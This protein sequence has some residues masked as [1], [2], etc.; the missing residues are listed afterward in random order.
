MTNW[1]YG[2]AG[3]RWPVKVGDI[4]QAGP[5]MLA[6]G[7]IE[8]G[9]AVELVMK[10]R[11]CPVMTYVDPPYTPALATGFR[12]KAG[13]PRKVDFQA[14]MR[15]I[16]R[17]VGITKGPVLM[18]MGRQYADE[19]TALVEQ[20]G[21]IVVSRWDITYFKKNPAVLLQLGFGHREPM[22]D[23]FSGMDDE[24]T[25]TVAIAAGSTPDALVF[26]PCTGRGGTCRAAHQLSR[27]FLGLELH[28]R[29]LACALD[30]LHNHGLQPERVGALESMVDQRPNSVLSE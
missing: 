11:E 29:R 23:L 18:E 4:W 20:D 24:L 30:W 22:G 6:C 21:G 16:I 2:D 5:H 12:T 28:P 25:P 17:A 14:L 8:Q 3:D 7:D 27:R 15:D 1:K 10:A 26:D 9:A 19:V 13:V